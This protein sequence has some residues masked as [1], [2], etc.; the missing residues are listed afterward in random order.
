MTQTTETTTDA[1]TAQYL[2]VWNEAD[3]A[4]RRAAVTALWA[5]DG[6]E[7]V[8][9][10]QHRGHDELTARV[11]GAYEKFVATGEYTITSAGDEA[12]HGDLV[13]FTARLTTPAG[14]TAWAARVFLLVGADG[15][16]REDYQLVVQPL[17]A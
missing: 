15:L 8:H 10:V 17:A 14:A 6:A 16:I 4:A 13:T 5:A 2:A 12:R 11:T 3:P 1:I 9:E 7:F